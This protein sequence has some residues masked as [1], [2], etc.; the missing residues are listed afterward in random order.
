MDLQKRG[1][2]FV[3]ITATEEIRYIL[4]RHYG[5]EVASLDEYRMLDL[6][7]RDL[8]PVYEYG[9]EEYLSIL[10]RYKVLGELT[11]A[12]RRRFFNIACDYWNS[13]IDDHNIE[14]VIFKMVPHLFY[15]FVIHELCEERGIRKVIIEKTYWE[16]V[17]LLQKT[18]RDTDHLKPDVGLNAVKDVIGRIKVTGLPYW[19]EA[20][21]ANQQR[22]EELYQ[23]LSGLSRGIEVLK[24]LL[25]PSGTAEY[26]FYHDR[27][28]PLMK[29]RRY[30]RFKQL[31]IRK[32]IAKN[33]D[34]ILRE[35]HESITDF[36]VVRGGRNIIF[37]LQ[38]QPEKSTTPLG[39]KYWNQLFALE[40]ILK[41]MPDGY[42]LLV[43][44][45]PS[46]FTQWQNLERGRFPGYYNKIKELGCKL[47]SH[48]I[49]NQEL[50]D[51]SEL[52]MS[53]SGS[54]VFEAWV[55]GYKAAFLGFPW[56]GIFDIKRILCQE[57]LLFLLNGTGESVLYPEKIRAIRTLGFTGYADDLSETKFIIENNLQSA[58]VQLSSV[59]NEY[60]HARIS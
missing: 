12:T 37:F 49:K 2:E 33:N 28:V 45:H 17:I 36:D 44:E 14:F 1:M 21:I 35:Y 38:C 24:R 57:D 26:G 3:F 53:V 13:Y 59:I 47:I 48:K 27:Y 22:Q 51:Y 25:R 15:D 54:I 42:N 4:R 40:E 46:Q 52:V 43:K 20:K 16:D 19:T 50:F 9:R 6:Y 11:M 34:K 58:A 60:A 41:W 29:I 55:L 5:L 39:G 7:A 10:D 30:G 8:L 56:Y 23:E 32:K 18:F 31:G